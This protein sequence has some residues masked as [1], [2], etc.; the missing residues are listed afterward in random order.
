MYN[1]AHSSME[2]GKR[3]N[4]VE[5]YR[6]LY[7]VLKMTW[8]LPRKVEEY[9]WCGLWRPRINWSYSDPC[10]SNQ[11]SIFFQLT[12]VDHS[13]IVSSTNTSHALNIEPKCCASERANSRA[14]MDHGQR[15]I[16]HLHLSN[17]EILDVRAIFNI[18]CLFRR[19][20]GYDWES[21]NRNRFTP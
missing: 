7:R 18:M 3:V 17:L 14:I 1:L 2:Q 15:F 16:F 20:V 19:V 6:W 13:E 21:P 8:S 4:L 5:I 11:R 12:A 10:F 9:T